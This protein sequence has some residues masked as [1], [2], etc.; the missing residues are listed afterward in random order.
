MRAPIDHIVFSMDLEK[1]DGRQQIQNILIMLALQANAHRRKA[2][3]KRLHI[4]AGHI[5]LW[6]HELLPAVTVNRLFYTFG[7]CVLPP[8]IFSH[9]P[10]GT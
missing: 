3:R 9:R 6:G 1:V 8:A 5:I 4:I 10:A 7:F 2:G